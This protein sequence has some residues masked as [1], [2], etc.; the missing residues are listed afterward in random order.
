VNST[1]N[2]GIPQLRRIKEE[3]IRTALILEKGE[4]HW[5]TI[6]L[7][8]NF[9]ARHSNYLQVSI[10]A[11][12]PDDFLKWQRLC[13]SRLRLLISSLETPQVSA[14]PFAKLFR[15]KYTTKGVVRSGNMELAIDGLQESF[16]FIALRFAPGVDSV[17]L[18]Y[19]FSDFLHKVNSWEERKE[20]MDLGIAHI[21]QKELP[22]SVVDDAAAEDESA[23]LSKV[24][25]KESVDP[26]KPAREENSTRLTPKLARSALSDADIASPAKRARNEN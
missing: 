26:A 15:Q 10:R 17:N 23:P 20:G 2:V 14:W 8:T 5:R 19:C 6:F 13:E 11:N 21:L 18:R 25:I 16:F 24:A 4:R 22:A 12:N 9:F 1:Y 3:M 7:R